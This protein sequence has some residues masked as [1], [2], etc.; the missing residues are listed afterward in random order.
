MRSLMP[1]SP[2]YDFLLLVHCT[3]LYLH[4]HRISSHHDSAH[5]IRFFIIQKV[6]DDVIHSWFTYLVLLTE[7]V[8]G[9]QPIDWR[10]KN[11]VHV[12]RWC[13]IITNDCMN[14]Q[15][16]IIEQYE[17]YSTSELGLII[18]QVT[19]LLTYYLFLHC[20]DIIWKLRRLMRI[21]DWL[22]WGWCA[23]MWL[24]VMNRLEQ[25]TVTYLN[26]ALLLTVMRGE[27]QVYDIYNAFIVD[28]LS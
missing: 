2:W 6:W 23:V 28:V 18:L 1:W 21:W 12:L 27:I 26:G 19:V 9:G 16:I 20:M 25:C 3:P 7:F 14:V 13:G 22:D 24:D 10:K 11:D 4:Y 15:I 17:K 5:H 8:E